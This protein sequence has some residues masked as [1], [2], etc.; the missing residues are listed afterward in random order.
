[1]DVVF[2]SVETVEL[3]HE[4]ALQE[5]GGMPGVRARELLESAVFQPQQS[6]FGEDAYCSFA[7]KAASYGFFIAQNQPFVDG[8]KRTAAAAM[9]A[10][11]YLNGFALAQSDDE[12]YEAFIRIGTKEW[13]Q[14]DFFSWVER[15]IV[16]ENT[17]DSEEENQRKEQT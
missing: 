3:F 14:E 4:R 13:S 8:N 10:F 7:S 15:S 11:L 16:A 6:A 5:H 1:M 9:L 17:T 2:L 12:I